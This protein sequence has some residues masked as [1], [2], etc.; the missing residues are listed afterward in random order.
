M[1]L[2]GTLYCYRN[3]LGFDPSTGDKIRNPWYDVTCCPPNLERTF[4]SLPGYMYST[5]N[6][7]VYVHLYE[8]S[9]LDWHLENGTPLKIAQ[10]TSYPWEGD[11]HFTISPAK[12]SEFTFYLRIPAWA[13]TAAVEVNGKSV[14]D[15]KPGQYLPIQRTWNP[16]DTIRLQ[17]PMNTQVLEANPHIAE[18]AGRVAVQR[19]P[20]VYCMEEVD[21]PNGIDLTNVA[22]DLGHDPGSGFQAEYR[23]DLLGGITVLRHE[24]IATER[25]NN[26]LYSRYSSQHK[27]RRVPLTFIPYYAWANREPSTMQVWTPVLRA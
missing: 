23:K 24:G 4:A 13:D 22:L 14:S 26:L 6:D 9:E 1:S 7:G 16:G 20:L 10:T 12:P 11:V 17:L 3:P 21:Q 8:N 27:T 5:S 25:S 18:D 2:D 19:G 15:P